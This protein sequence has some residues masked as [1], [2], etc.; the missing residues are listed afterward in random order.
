MSPHVVGFKTGDLFS[1]AKVI[2]PSHS[3]TEGY[4]LVKKKHMAQL[5]W[6]TSCFLIFFTEKVVWDVFLHLGY[7]ALIRYK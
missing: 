3:L 7:F 1:L 4:Y 2:I 6:D 5:I